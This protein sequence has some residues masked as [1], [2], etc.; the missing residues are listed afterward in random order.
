M[1]FVKKLLLKKYRHI[2]SVGILTLFILCAGGFFGT[3]GWF[4]RTAWLW[5]WAPAPNPTSWSI[6]GYGFGDN[7][8][9][10]GT[11]YGYITWATGSLSTGYNSGTQWLLG[12]TTTG[13][14][15]T[16]TGTFTWYNQIYIEIPP[17]TTI[18]PT[19]GGTWN[20]QIQIPTTGTYT[21]P[22]A[23]YQSVVN[24][25]FSFVGGAFFS[26]P[27][28]IT[29]PVSV[30][31][32]SV[33]VDHRD[34]N[35]L[36]TIGLTLSAT[37][38][39]TSWV[40]SAPYTGS[41]ITSVNGTI[42][43]YTCAAS[44]FV[45][46]TLPV[47]WWGAYDTVGWW[48]RWQQL[49]TCPNGDKSLNP[50]DGK[51]NDNNKDSEKAKK[52]KTITSSW[53]VLSNLLNGFS[54]EFNDAYTFAFSKGITTQSTIQ[55]ANMTWAL[56]RAS[57]A[58]MIVN[59]AVNVL[60]KAVDSWVVCTFADMTGQSTEMQEYAIKACQ[61]WL[62]GKGQSNFNPKG[63]VTRAQ[64]WTVLSRMLYATPESGA[65]YYTV[66][67]NLL[68]DK[69]VLTMIDSKLI[70]KRVYLMLMLMRAAATPPPAQ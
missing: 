33:G 48:G 49:D 6:Y 68:K 55:K 45:A 13:N 5:S 44:T 17:G 24:L 11:G 50:Y 47:W 27:V 7:G 22:S 51:C 16:Q 57:M 4:I 40:A 43:I 9:W 34:G 61:L 60:G 52:V 58:K 25:D 21:I 29:I 65:P 70:E 30:A 28:K 15:T 69:W 20:G 53:E 2:F 38:T 64:L 62:M 36:G 18:T 31:S 1:F 37:A 14:T 3:F 23:T 54:Q 12:V 35:W 59:Y 67:L 63:I 46:Y 56:T 8:R 66:H 42:T 32:A 26:Q 19:S 39:C 10:Y 41:P